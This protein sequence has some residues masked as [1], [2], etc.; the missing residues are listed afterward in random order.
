MKRIFSLALISTIVTCVMMLSGCSLFETEHIH[1]YEE[2]TMEKEATCTEDGS[3]IRFC[4]CGDTEK[5]TLPKIGHI[6]KYTESA[7]ES[8]NITAILLCQGNGCESY[9][10]NTAGLYNENDVLITS[11][12]ELVSVYRLDIEKDYSQKNLETD[13]TLLQNIIK[14][15]LKLQEGTKLIVADSVTRIGNFAFFGCSSL[16]NLIVPKSVT[17]IGYNSLYRCNFEMIYTGTAEEWAYV[18]RSEYTIGAKILIRY[19]D[20]MEFVIVNFVPI[21]GNAIGSYGGLFVKV[22]GGKVYIGNSLN[23]Y[24][25]DYVYYDESFELEYKELETLNHPLISESE[26]QEMSDI[27][28]KIKKADTWYMLRKHENET[29]TNKYLVCMVDNAYYFVPITQIAE[30]ENKFSVVITA[31]CRHEFGGYIDG[32]S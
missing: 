8:G 29:Y 11:W 17:Y 4:S 25:Y 6:Y 10:T 9:L 23:T 3:K 13:E 2:W 5:E 21:F 1:E 19:E 22:D 26:R 20:K 27:L 14:N 30:T 24:L 12:D 28:D 32:N 15:N 7:D 16:K 18:E 31:I